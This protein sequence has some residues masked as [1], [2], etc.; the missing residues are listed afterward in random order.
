M[1]SRPSSSA[2]PCEDPHGEIEKARARGVKG[3]RPKGQSIATGEL[4]AWLLS[5][6]VLPHGPEDLAKALGCTKLQGFGRSGRG[7]AIGSGPTS[8]RR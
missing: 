5:R 2:L 7:L 8:W 6:G 3:G 1:E 4:R